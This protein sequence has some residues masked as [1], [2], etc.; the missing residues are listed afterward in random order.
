MSS[1]KSQG[2]RFNIYKPVTFIYT[3]SKLL[4]RKLRKLSH[5]QS[6]QKE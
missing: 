3:N 6:H 4:E 1:L 5:L 2:K